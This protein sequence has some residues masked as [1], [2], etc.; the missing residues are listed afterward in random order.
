MVTFASADEALVEVEQGQP[1]E[2]LITD[3]VLPG[4]LQGNTLA[5]RVKSLRPGV[6]VLYMSGYTR[7]AIV[8][9]GRLD[10]G[11]NFMEKPFT[12]DTLL[13]TVRRLLDQAR[14]GSPKRGPLSGRVQPAP[15][16]RPRRPPG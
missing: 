5:D 10:Q 16:V 11:V 8:H 12:P 4:V 9:A 3:V 1:F 2:L 7:N 15:R 14:A 6:T 13:K